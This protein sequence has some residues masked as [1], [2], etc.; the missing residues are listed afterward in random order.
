MP[1]GV[2]CQAG[3][4][5][6]Q[7]A[8]QASPRRS[9]RARSRRSSTGGRSS[10]AWASSP[11][12]CRCR[13]KSLGLAAPTLIVCTPGQLRQNR[14]LTT[15][16][17]Q[18]AQSSNRRWEGLC[19]WPPLSVGLI[20]NT[21]MS[22][23][24][25]AAIAAALSWRIRYQC[26][27]MKSKRSLSIASK[28]RGRGAWVEK[29]TEPIRPWSCQRRATSRQPP[30]RRAWSRCLGWLMPWIDSRSIRPGEP[31]RSS[32][33][34]SKL[35]RSSASKRSGSSWGGSLVWSRRS[36]SGHSGNNQPSWR[37][38]VP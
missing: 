11:T 19:R 18:G 26:R 32:P 17:C 10:G 36:G 38:E 33:S 21:P 16:G 7:L 30:G 12:A 34:R 15:I 8:S 5:C 6:C 4:P 28:I 27:L 31:G 9:T 3:R 22:W 37:S 25:A 13:S 23:R 2:S 1:P 14:S 24:R 35:R 20:R 29:P